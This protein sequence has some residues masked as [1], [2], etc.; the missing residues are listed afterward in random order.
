METVSFTLLLN[1]LHLPGLYDIFNIIFNVY[2][3]GSLMLAFKLK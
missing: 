3:I 1:H 2:F